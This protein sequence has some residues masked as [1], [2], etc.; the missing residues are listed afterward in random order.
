MNFDTVGGRAVVKSQHG[1]THIGRTA[2]GATVESERGS[3]YVGPSGGPVAVR[4]NRGEV[5]VDAPAG[6]VMVENQ[7][8]G[9]VVRADQPIDSAYTLTNSRGNIQVTVP[10]DSSLEV[11]GIVRRGRVDTDLP[12]SV[13]G[14]GQ[15]GQT[16]S[17]RIGS[18]HGSL[19]AEVEGGNLVLKRRQN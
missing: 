7:R 8:A 13:S 3:V 19:R 17:G 9:I 12:L 10:D 11:Q 4:N 14:N 16:V 15:D 2:S 5:I 18:G 1:P 6:D